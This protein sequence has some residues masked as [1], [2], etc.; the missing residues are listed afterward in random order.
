MSM[1]LCVYVGVK[2]ITVEST[3]SMMT[4]TVDSFYWNSQ[5]YLLVCSLSLSL[6]ANPLGNNL[7]SVWGE[8]FV[9]LW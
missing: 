8:K 3:I 6:T 9:Q 2:S 4:C 7:I 1:S 5:I